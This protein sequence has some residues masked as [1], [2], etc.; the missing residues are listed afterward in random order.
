MLTRARTV[1]GADEPVSTSAGQGAE[2]PEA[3]RFVGID[4]AKAELEVVERPSGARWTVPNDV[5]GWGQLREQLAAARPTLVVLEATAGYE[6]GVV[7]SL[8]AAGLPV[9]VL[10]PRQVRDFA[11]A[12]GRLAKTDALDAAV[13]A[14]F[15]DVVRPPVR[16]LTEP[17]TEALEAW[18][19]RR[20]QLV[21]MLTAEEQRR[22]RA[23]QAIQRQIDAHV[24]WLRRQL[25]VVE[26]DLTDT[27]RASPVWRGE[28]G[29]VGGV[30]GGGPIMAA[31]LLAALPG[32]RRPHPQQNA[33]PVAGAPPHPDQ[34][35]PPGRPP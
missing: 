17:V 11:K 6:L 9:V 18:L 31:A 30:P 28:G 5:A 35:T 25:E 16:P 20:R 14:H 33:A 23:P 32:P 19:T 29:R 2:M 10:N 8:A 4:V 15:A 22:A 24:Q 27:L 21:D 26:K 13:L 7:A 34:C 12:I 1:T 3:G